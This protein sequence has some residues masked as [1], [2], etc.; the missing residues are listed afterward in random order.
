M[1]TSNDSGS[2]DSRSNDYDNSHGSDVNGGNDSNRFRGQNCNRNG[3]GKGCS[4][5]GNNN[6]P[7]QVLLVA[8][9]DLKAMFMMAL[10]PIK[11]THV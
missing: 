1:G 4:D 3:E 9:Q 11:P 10:E 8:H 2:D 6:N 7:T 5:S